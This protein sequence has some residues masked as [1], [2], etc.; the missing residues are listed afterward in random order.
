MKT[1]SDQVARVS[2]ALAD[3][4][5][6]EI[7][8]LLLSKDDPLS[9]KEVAE[10]F[11]LHSNA[12]R[13]HLEKLVKG[14]LLRMIRRR[15]A[16]GGRPAHLYCTCEEE[17]ELHLPPRRYK[18]LADILLEGISNLD[19]PVIEALGQEAFRCGRDEAM[20]TSSALAYLTPESG[21]LQVADAWTRE[22]KQRGLNVESRAAGDDEVEVTFLSCPFGELS[23][24]SPE[25]ICGIHRRMEEGFLSLAGD[26]RLLGVE[27]ARC[28]F[29]L[30]GG[31]G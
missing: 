7:L 18:L 15:G 29:I 30:N 20:R 17:W 22:I 21:A 4:T 6:R 24:R 31:A 8:E 10:H 9:V 28:T 11:G 14:G 25:I 1:Y 2:T 5:R 3:P 23:S 27:G 19:H 13:M 12:A 16:G 26:W